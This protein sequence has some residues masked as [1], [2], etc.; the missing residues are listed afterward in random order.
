MRKQGPLWR[1]APGATGLLAIGLLA[2]GGLATTTPAAASSVSNGSTITLG[3]ASLGFGASTTYTIS[4]VPVRLVVG[5]T[6]SLTLTA[7]AEA[8]ST[9]VISLSNDPSSYTVTYAPS[10]GT[11]SPDAVTSALSVYGGTGVLLTL[12]NPL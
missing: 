7:Q 6:T 2:G 1:L 9:E 3:A 8:G 10:G 12:A 4:N 11:G 5:S